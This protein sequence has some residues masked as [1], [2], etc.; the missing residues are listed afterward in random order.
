MKRQILVA[1]FLAA[2]MQVTNAVPVVFASIGEIRGRVV[3]I[4]TKTGF[5]VDGYTIEFE[6]STDKKVLAK[7]R[8][9]LI[10]NTRYDYRKFQRLRRDQTLL[11]V[12]RSDK[13]KVKVGDFVKVVN[14]AIVGHSESGRKDGEPTLKSFEKA[15]QKNKKG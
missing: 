4:D 13:V 1:I 11:L 5:L 9:A 6:D 8:K 10:S 3:A 7:V 15:L 12:R 14:Y 2:L